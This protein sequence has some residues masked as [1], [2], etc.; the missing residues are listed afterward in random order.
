MLNAL[1]AR[2]VRFRARVSPMTTNPARLRRLKPEMISSLV[3]IARG[4]Y[5]VFARPTLQ[6]AM[7]RPHAPRGLLPDRPDYAASRSFALFGGVTVARI[8][9][10]KPHLNAGLVTVGD[11]YSLQ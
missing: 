9:L 11:Y 10:E 5:R 2:P 3:S 8:W 1:P 7:R 4:H 6:D